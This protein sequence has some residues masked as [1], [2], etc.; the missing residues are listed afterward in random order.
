MT[1]MQSNEWQKE[2]VARIG[3]AIDRARDG[4]S[5]QWI[6]DRTERLG[7]PLSR[8]A[9]SEYRRGIRK[10]I[11]VADWLT[12]AAALG[13]PP[14]SLLFPDLPDGPVDLFPS[15]PMVNSFDALL[16]VTGERISFPEGSDVL[17]A[18]DDGRPMAEVAGK[19]EYR[20]TLGPYS[21]PLNWR[22][23]HESSNEGYVLA[24][25][26]ELKKLLVELSEIET[27]FKLFDYLGPESERQQVMDSYIK[28]LTEKQ[29]QITKIDELLKSRGAI[30]QEE[31]LTPFEDE[32]GER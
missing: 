10:T 1:G 5:D 30:V 16:W 17:L 31:A 26:R 21:G 15:T 25:L 18:M 7:N 27:P 23:E 22:D 24:Q 14:V 6:A 9:V 32:D 19:R 13:V 29:R 4:K 8:T 28:R 3:R 12:L 20:D 11:T 2:L